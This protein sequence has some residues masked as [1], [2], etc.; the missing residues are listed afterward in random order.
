MDTTP[1]DSALQPLSAPHSMFRQWVA[2]NAL[3]L[4][5]GMAL[6]AAVAEGIER[7]GILGAP[8]LGERVGHIIGLALAGS[9]FGLMQRRVLRRYVALSGW[10]L[11][12]TMF[13]LMLGY[14]LGYELGGPPRSR[15]CSAAC[16]SGWPCDG[17]ARAADGGL[18]SAHSDAGWAESLAPRWLSWVWVR[19]SAG[20]CRPGSF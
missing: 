5:L 12:G 2:A 19:H 11:L 8:E 15:D 7:S 6:F 20:V 14:I 17:R 10:M 3:G 1:Q 4:G 16:S 13:G 18:L 9:F